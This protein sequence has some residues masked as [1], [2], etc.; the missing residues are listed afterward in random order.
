[1]P[2]LAFICNDCA[3]PEGIECKTIGYLSEMFTCDICGQTFNAKNDLYGQITWGQHIKLAYS[4]INNE[5][6]DILVKLYLLSKY[7]DEDDP[8]FCI[9]ALNAMPELLRLARLGRKFEENIKEHS[10]Q[11]TSRVE[12]EKKLESLGFEV[13][14][15]EELE[16][17]KLGRL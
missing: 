8:T 1:M 7:Y 13:P 15:E 14:T 10:E 6:T 11:E 12:R 16:R 17:F 2:N 5:T 4:L 9:A 3:P